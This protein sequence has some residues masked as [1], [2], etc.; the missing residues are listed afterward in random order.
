[1]CVG[2]SATIIISRDSITPRYWYHLT[3]PC[4][5]SVTFRGVSYFDTS[6]A[7]VVGDGGLLFATSN[8]GA[9]WQ[10]PV[11]GLTRQTLRAAT[12]TPG[13]HVIVVGDSGIILH[14]TNAGSTWSK[15]SSNTTHN[16]NGISINGVGEGYCVGNH[17]L[18]EFTSDFGNS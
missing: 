16:I 4:G 10:S 12:G 8:S 1:M 2:D 5:L 3:A 14:S 9:T 18:I 17:G 15:L 13:G 6:H 11:A 7:V